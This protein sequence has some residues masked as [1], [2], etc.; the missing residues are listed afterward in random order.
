MKRWL[1]TL[2]LL[3]FMSAVASMIL[4]FVINPWRVR[5]KHEAEVSYIVTWCYDMNHNLPLPPDPH[6]GS[7]GSFSFTCS[8]PGA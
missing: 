2:V 6:F 7:D 5:R 1:L 4:A 8:V 3:I